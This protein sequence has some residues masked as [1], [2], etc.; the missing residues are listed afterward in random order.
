MRQSTENIIAR[1]GWV[2]K[3][4]IAAV[5]CYFIYTQVVEREGLATLIAVARDA[6]TV[7]H[8]RVLLSAVLVG[9]L[10]NWGLEGLKWK[11]VLRPLEQVSITKA[12]EAVF[13]GL[14]VSFFTPNRVGEYAGRVFHLERADRPQAIL[15]TIVENV[16]QL[17]ITLF[18]G[19]IALA[20]G[21]Q[22]LITTQSYLMSSLRILSLVGAVLL[23][24]AFVYSG[25][26]QAMFVR[27]RLS[28]RWLR[29]TGILERYPRARFVELLLLSALR[30]FVFTGQFFLLLHVFGAP[31]PYGV[32][33][34]RIALTYLAMSIVPSIA[35]TELGVRGAL[36]AWVFQP[37][38]EQVSG[39][40]LATS[41]LWVINLVIPALIGLIF[42]FD[43]KF[44]RKRS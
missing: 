37:V 13:S 18:F 9:M 26:L 31:L 23:L 43:F 38:T 8:N 1:W 42:V 6:W 39:V 30:Y 41:A 25:V 10:L 29:V 35:L 33:I 20:V 22:D 24:L 44:V 19:G 36:A 14:S 27:L 7:S 16:S 11:L 34:L 21:V 15:A 40:L 28:G 17:V 4:L 5:A 3:L 2:L 12:L 32:A